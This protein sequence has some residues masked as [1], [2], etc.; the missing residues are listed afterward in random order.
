M[1]ETPRE[2]EAEIEQAR[3]RLGQNLNALEYRV[4]SELDWRTQFDRKPWAFLAAAFGVSFLIGWILAP[5]GT[6]D[7][8]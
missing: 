6:A 7:E 1:G 2:I 8:S 5:A 4:K 3:N